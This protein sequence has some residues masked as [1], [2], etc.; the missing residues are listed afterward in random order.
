MRPVNLKEEMLKTGEY[1]PQFPLKHMTKDL[2]FALR[3]A[4]EA[5]AALPSGTALF[6]LYRE[7]MGQGLAD[8]DFCAVKKILERRNDR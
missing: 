5:G 1:P 8:L 2:R 7:A 6:Q 4:D 3:T